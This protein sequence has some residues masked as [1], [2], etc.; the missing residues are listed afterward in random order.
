MPRSHLQKRESETASARDQYIRTLVQNVRNSLSV[1]ELAGTHGCVA[2][3]RDEGARIYATFPLPP[4]D[5][6]SLNTRKARS[7]TPLDGARSAD[8][9]IRVDG[10]TAPCAH[11]E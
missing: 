5:V 6:R 4:G 9:T 3:R 1:G 10:S 8:L 7:K 2:G 11:T